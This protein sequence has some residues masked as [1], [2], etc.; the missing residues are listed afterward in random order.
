MRKKINLCFPHCLFG[1]RLESLA[2]IGGGIA[3]VCSAFT[4][5][6]LITSRMAN[7]QGVPVDYC[8]FA[9]GVASD[10]AEHR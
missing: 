9:L 6:M 2:R 8:R 3:I 1:E 7:A 5:A 4:V 10:H